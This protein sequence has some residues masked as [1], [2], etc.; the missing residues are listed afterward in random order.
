MTLKDFLQH[1]IFKSQHGL[2]IIPV[3][4]FYV[5]YSNRNICNDVT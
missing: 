3:S 4:L 2:G 1:K 5:Y